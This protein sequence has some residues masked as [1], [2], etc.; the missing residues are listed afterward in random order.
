MNIEEVR[1][2]CLTLKNTTESQPFGEEYVVFKVEEKMFLL[3]TLEAFPPYIAVKCD[4]ELVEELR[5]R[6]EAVTPAFHFHKK[7]WNGIVL[8]SDMTGDEIKYWIE[9]SYRQV[10]AKLPKKIREIY[11]D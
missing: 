6:Y 7:Y 9:H 10:I 3:L 8:D 5:D 11:N 4:P 2:Y 1:E